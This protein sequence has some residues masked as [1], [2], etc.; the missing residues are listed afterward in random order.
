MSSNIPEYLK[1]AIQEKTSKVSPQKLA[2]FSQKLS[3]RYR[4]NKKMNGSYM[5]SQEDFLAYLT[6][7][8]P[9]T[10]GAIHNVLS[11]VKE[12]VPLAFESILDVGA[13]PGTGTLAAQEVFIHLKRATLV[14]KERGLNSLSKEL[15][16]RNNSISCEWIEKDLHTKIEFEE[17]DLILMG[18]VLGEL[19]ENIWQNLVE[20]LWNATKKAIIFIEPGTPAG[21]NRI[22][23]VRKFLIS[24]GGFLIAPCPH[25][26]TCPLAETDW[27]H[28]AQ[29]IERT[30]QHRLAKRAELNYEDEKFSYVAFTKEVFAKE[31]DR[32]IRRPLKRP[33]HVQFNLCSQEGIKN[34]I[35]SRKNKDFYHKA[36]K[37]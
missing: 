26:N 5:H 14:E 20:R 8:F 16:C 21:F 33:G 3:T 10:F 32:V 9:A 27:C 19:S 29:R 15:I 17:H 4:D 11:E 24:L 6:T 30:S 25:Q 37:S 13:G 35:I 7:R 22:L 12:R 2:D 28:F 36:K 31:G 18:Y 34:K 1:L 23:K